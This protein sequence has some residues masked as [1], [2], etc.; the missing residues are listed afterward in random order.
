LD[1]CPT[2]GKAG[3]L[4]KEAFAPHLLTAKEIKKRKEERR[5]EREKRKK[6][7]KNKGR[8]EKGK[9]NMRTSR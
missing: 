6:E 8:R 9:K 4:Y 1:T 5:K 7:E 2:Y 3:L